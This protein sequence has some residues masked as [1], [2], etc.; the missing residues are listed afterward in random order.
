[1]SKTLLITGEYLASLRACQTQRL[2]F[3][4]MFPQG[5]VVTE[6][7][8]LAHAQDFDFSWAILV[9]LE[10]PH[11]KGARIKLEEAEDFYRA[12]IRPCYHEHIADFSNKLAEKAFDRVTHAA[13][14]NFNERIAVVFADAF[15]AQGGRDL[16]EDESL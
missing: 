6:E 7:L 16:L 3:T 2:R 12:T 13:R 10:E 4:E 5:V 8:A 1:M 9:M 15:I 14:E 11:R